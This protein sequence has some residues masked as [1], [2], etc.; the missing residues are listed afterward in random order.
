MGPA[1]PSGRGGGTSARGP[2][3]WGEVAELA[4]AAVAEPATAP[5][6]APAA[7]GSAIVDY[8]RQFPGTPYVWGGS[9]P[10]GFDCSGFTQHVYA[11]SGINLPR[12][13]SARPPSGSECPLPRRD[14]DHVSRPDLHCQWCPKQGRSRVSMAPAGVATADGGFP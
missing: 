13:S 4:T 2:T 3:A 6:P 5:A 11:T 14:S 8:A 12:S 7:S 10:A 9:T 1:R